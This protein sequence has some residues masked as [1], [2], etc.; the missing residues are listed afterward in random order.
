MTS[1]KIHVFENTLCLHCAN[2]MGN[3][4][5]NSDLQ[6]VMLSSTLTTIDDETIVFYDR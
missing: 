3:W 6:N 5:L 4:D 2:F 1:G